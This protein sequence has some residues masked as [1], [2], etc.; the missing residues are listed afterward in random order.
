MLEGDAATLTRQ[1][2]VN[3]EI[4]DCSLTSICASIELLTGQFYP[5]DMRTATDYPARGSGR[6]RIGAT[7]RGI[8]D[9]LI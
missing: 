6:T 7:P 4:A 8:N 9:A 3:S 2:Q 1:P 5:L